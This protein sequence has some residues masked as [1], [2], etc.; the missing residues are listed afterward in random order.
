MDLRFLPP[1]EFDRVYFY[2]A[3]TL[4]ILMATAGIIV[5]NSGAATR[6]EFAFAC[7]CLLAF[8][9]RFALEWIRVRRSAPALLDDDALVFSG[10][11]AR[12]RIPLRSIRTVRSTHS[13]LM[14]RRYRSWTQCIAFLDITLTNG[15]R[16]HTLVESAVL[17]FP[18][19]KETLRAI[20]SAVAAAKA[21]ASASGLPRTPQV[22]AEYPR[23][24]ERRPDKRP[25]AGRP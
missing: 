8:G 25:R 17:E 11:N 20:R 2:R 23:H 22:E 6:V 3:L 19:G 7:A 15:K 1:A 13:I 4:V 24:A 10:A 16:V 18:A 12:R 14:A 5:F 21:D 9:W